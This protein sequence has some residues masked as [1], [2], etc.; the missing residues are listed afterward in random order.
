[1][2]ERTRSRSFGPTVLVGLAGATLA[3]VAGAQEW[4]RASG[5]AAGADVTAAAQGSESAPLV[6]A[7]GLVSLAAWGV[8][9]VLRGGA[10]RVVAVFG[11]M[12]AAGVLASTAGS[13]DRAQDDAVSA[14]VAKG[15]DGDVFTAALTGWYYAAG[16][17]ALLTLTAFVVAVVVAP[18]WPA[19]SSR[20]DAPRMHAAADG[21]EPSSEQDLWRALDDGRDPTA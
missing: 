4:A 18:R 14:V 6:V 11:A 15:A 7:L 13:F 8:V 9:L 17:G 2:T 1:M 10:R 12:A 20:Y 5:K 3:A 21:T 19:M 16:V